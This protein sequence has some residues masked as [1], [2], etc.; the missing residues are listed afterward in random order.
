MAASK[1]AATGPARAS[2]TS[3]APR[4]SNAVGAASA[5]GASDA[6]GAASAAS[7]AAA[8]GASRAAAVVEHTVSIHGHEMAYRTAGRAPG[9]NGA[10]AGDAGP[11][12]P[13]LLL[14]HGIAG[15]ARTWDAIL[16]LLGRWAYVVVPDLP[17]HGGSEPA[18]GDCSISSYASSLRDLMRALDLSPATVVGHS[19]GGGVAMQL[20]Y[21]F[22]RSVQRLILIAAGGL[23]PEVSLFLRAAT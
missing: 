4:A 5:A 12:R 16:P 19:L 9:P 1:L 3:R 21:M 14:V 2:R 10:G 11:D 17:G 20:S 13:T 8:I 22:P 15:D 7:A 6:V 23:G 18:S